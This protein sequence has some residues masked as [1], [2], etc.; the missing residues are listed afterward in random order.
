MTT[1]N[2][3]T[4][5]LLKSILEAFNRHDLD[6]IMNFMTQ[7]CVLEMPRGSAPWGQRSEGSEAVRQALS[8]R[9]EGITDVHDGEDSH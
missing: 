9:Y 1:N 3:V 7:D 2:A 6:T 8:G 5:E 4:V